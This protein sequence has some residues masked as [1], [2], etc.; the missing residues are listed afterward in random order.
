MLSAHLWAQEPGTCVRNARGKTVCP[1]RGSTCLVNAKDEVACSPPFGGIVTT[2]YGQLLCGPGKCMTSIIGYAFCS[3]EK[4]GWA[5]VN[6]AG[7]PVC[8]GGCVEATA[9]ACDW[10]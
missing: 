4:G 8:S 1:A 2:L 9:P 10:Q 7:E 5:A 6:D 3:S